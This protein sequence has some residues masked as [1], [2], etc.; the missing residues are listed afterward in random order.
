MFCDE[1][2][3]DNVR[4]SKFKTEIQTN[5]GTGHVTKEGDLPGFKTMMFSDQ[6]IANLLA[7][8]EL[9]E[10][11]H[12]T[13]D[14]KKENAFIVK[15]NDGRIMKFSCDKEG[16][17]SY[18]P[19]EPKD[20]VEAHHTELG[21]KENQVRFEKVHNEEMGPRI[22]YANNRK[23]KGRKKIYVKGYNRREVERAARA[24]RMYH[25][26]TAPD[27]AELK[28]FIRQNIMKNCP[29]TTEDVVL[30]KKSLAEMFLRSK[31]RA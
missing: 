12:V 29:V 23:R 28:K 11:Y 24:R 13:F 16:M 25:S 4:D 26:L 20:K 22:R 27:I 19:E 2:L 30:A 15:L 10:K 14:S 9:C 1:D 3:L 6:A 17:Y 21:S 31:E 7:L 5:T 18:L 8:N